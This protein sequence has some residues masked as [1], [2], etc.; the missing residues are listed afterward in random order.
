VPTTETLE[1]LERA[2]ET[3][4]AQGARLDSEGPPKIRH[5]IYDLMEV[6]WDPRTIVPDPDAPLPDLMLDRQAIEF[7]RGRRN[8]IP[9]EQR[10]L[11]RTT[12]LPDFQR[13]WLG[14]LEKVGVI[15]APVCSFPAMKHG[16]TW[17]FINAFNYTL[18]ISLIP[19]VPAGCVPFVRSKEGLPIGIQVIGPPFRED[20][21]L[22][23]MRCLE[24]ARAT[25]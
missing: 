4:V 22:A 14:Y 9:L 18:L 8:R 20:I 10:E 19:K 15:L 16:T 12:L 2:V 1:A 25:P 3:L 23:A 13:S 24:N 11:A 7:F 21:V 6:A 5:N 17:Q